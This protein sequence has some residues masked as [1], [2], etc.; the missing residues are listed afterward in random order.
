ME[1]G[2]LVDVVDHMP[3]ATI[4][5]MTIGCPMVLISPAAPPRSNA[6]T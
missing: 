5:F 3:T 6:S 4:I 2:V 1:N